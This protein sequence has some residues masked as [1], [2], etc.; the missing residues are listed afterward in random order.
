MA[1]RGKKC[2]AGAGAAAQKNKNTVA[3]ALNLLKN[4]DCTI[5]EKEAVRAV[6]RN[7]AKSGAYKNAGNQARHIIA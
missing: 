3:E 6:G 1:Q 7:A 4:T 5:S 2:Y